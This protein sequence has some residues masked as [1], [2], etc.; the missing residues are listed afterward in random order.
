ATVV[1]FLHGQALPGQVVDPLVA[2][3]DGAVAL[4]DPMLDAWRHDRRDLCLMPGEQPDTRPEERLAELEQ[5]M[6]Q[7]DLGERLLNSFTGSNVTVCTEE[8]YPLVHPTIAL[9]RS[10]YDAAIVRVDEG[11][12]EALI[13]HAHELR[14]AD[15]DVRG[16]FRLVGE[17]GTAQ[18]GLAMV[19]MVEADAS[20]FA[21][22][23][24]WQ[25]REAG[26]P[27]AW[28]FAM[29]HDTF[30]PLAEAFEQAMRQVPEGAVASEANIRAGMRA[31]YNAWFDPGFQDLDYA[32]K[33]HEQLVTIPQSDRGEPVTIATMRR[34]LGQLPGNAD[35]ASVS[36]LG[37]PEMERAIDRSRTLVPLTEPMP[38]DRLE[39]QRFVREDHAEGPK[40]A[41][42]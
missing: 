19:F 32:L 35:R 22:A 3:P 29:G 37:L 25:L 7:A 21:T 28:D 26:Q 30:R 24:A 39:G 6:R 8:A 12:G 36:Y 16:L 2:D 10:K 34:G 5:I 23:V 42:P 18:N 17:D 20:A 11:L 27:A 9:Y 40:F 14:H 33:L 15:Q 4:G 13:S 1:A 31:A 41:R 38:T